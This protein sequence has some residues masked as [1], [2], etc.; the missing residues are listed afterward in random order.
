[1]HLHSVFKK[2]GQFLI[3]PAFE[4][5]YVAINSRRVQ[6]DGSVVSPARVL[7]CSI[8][9][10]AA[11]SSVLSLLIHR[12]SNH[13]EGGFRTINFFCGSPRA[14]LL[15]RFPWGINESLSACDQSV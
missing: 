7:P 4:T 1:M 5:P 8:V 10:L 15:A 3:H 12:Y 9:I 13:V 11:R 14:A 6:C 2:L